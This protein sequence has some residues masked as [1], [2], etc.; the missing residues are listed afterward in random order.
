MGKLTI[1]EVEDL[2]KAKT[3]NPSAVRDM[4]EKG[5]VGTRKRGSRRY[6]KG[7]GN[8]TKIYPQLYFSGLGK[9]NEYTKDMIEIKKSFANL[10]K[11]YT[12]TKGESK[13]A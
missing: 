11:E 13:N 9:G 2:V 3:L 7:A 6:L 10:I 1:A 4:E 5:L 8:G 12:T